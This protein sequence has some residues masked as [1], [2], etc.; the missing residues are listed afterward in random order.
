LKDFSVSGPSLHRLSND[1][2]AWIGAGGDSNAGAVVTKGGLL[3]I[4]AQQTPQLGLGFRLRIESEAGCRATH[5][6]NTHLHLDHT[7]GNV[8][9]RDV[10]I[11]AHR[12]TAELLETELGPS[13]QNLW[14][15]SDTAAKLR[16]FFG[17]NFAEL[18]APTDSLCAWFL[19]RV[20][21][22]AYERI[23]LMGPTETFDKSTS[24]ETRDGPLVAEYWGAAH[25]DGD[26]IVYHP[27]QK[28]AFTGD[29][30]FVGRFPWLGDCDLD[31][32][33]AALERLKQMDIETVVPG[34]GPVC[35]LKDV[36]EF[37]DLLASL[38]RA[39]AQA[40]AAGASEDAARAEIALPKYATLPRYRE[41]LAPNVRAVYRY[42]KP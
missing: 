11:I 30:L 36:A 9:F 3:A 26:L 25:C 20:S 38:R 22:P 21:G 2:Y 1:V 32:W 16:L 10:P 33:I 8:V 5:L 18:V 41:W 42:L 24:F 31:G 29:L 35:T 19:D 37:R 27:Q 23:E 4:D 17:A 12:R 14:V 28:I 15:L 13:D 6:L 7:A 39:V 40:I 34:H